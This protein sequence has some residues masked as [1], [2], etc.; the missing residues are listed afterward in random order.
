MERWWESGVAYDAGFEESEHPRDESGRF[1]VHVIK[2]SGKIS[3]RPL[4]H[5]QYGQS[6][7]LH[8]AKEFKANLDKT[9]S[10]NKYAIMKHRK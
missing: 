2:K 3:E 10:W 7:E 5:M 4:V 6:M 9:A 1:G 8:H